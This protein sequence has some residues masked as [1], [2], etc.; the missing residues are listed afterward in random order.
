MTTNPT[1]TTGAAAA[2]S[3]TEP[4]ASGAAG[5][6]GET[7]GRKPLPP[8]STRRVNGQEVLK[9]R[10]LAVMDLEL[11]GHTPGEIAQRLQMTPQ[12]V[13]Y[14]RK[15]SLYQ[16]RLARRRREVEQDTN[17]IVA[18]SAAQTHAVLEKAAEEAAETLVDL[19]RGAASETIKFKSAKEIIDKTMGGGE[20]Q[21]PISINIESI[22]VLQQAM[23]ESLA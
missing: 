1:T 18:A 14:I 21:R 9:Q 22:Q 11:A 17:D 10:H 8:N 2:A 20:I 13:R 12:N 16:D 15:T 19:M 7:R 4:T 5:V 23:K 3:T 6:N